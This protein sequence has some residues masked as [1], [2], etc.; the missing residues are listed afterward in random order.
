[1]TYQ[2]FRN[3]YKNLLKKHCEI[4]NLYEAGYIIEMTKTEY[5]KIGTQWKEYKKEVKEVDYIHYC[6]IFDSIQFFKNLGGYE[7]TEKSYTCAGYIPTTQTSIS[8]DRTKKS[9]YS[10]YIHRQEG[11]KKMIKNI[12][13]F[14]WEKGSIND[15]I[16]KILQKKYKNS[17]DLWEQMW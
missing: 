1:M 17:I 14:I 8:P 16:R 7:K 2:E 13:R 12:G 4:S 11:M 6:N 9:V 5:Y 10:F 15:N 3:T